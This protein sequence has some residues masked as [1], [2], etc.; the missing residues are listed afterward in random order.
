MAPK[1]TKKATTGTGK[2]ATQTR[3][4]SGAATTSKPAGVSKAAAP[5]KTGK[6]AAGKVKGKSKKADPQD[7]GDGDEDYE[8]PKTKRGRK[9]AE[10]VNDESDEDP[11]VQPRRKHTKK[12]AEEEQDEPPVKQPTRRSARNKKGQNDAE[13]E[14]KDEPQAKPA[15][16]RGTR[17]KKAQDDAGEDQIPHAQPE[18]APARPKRKPKTKTQPAQAEPEE[19]SPRAEQPEPD[20][21][22]PAAEVADGHVQQDAEPDYDQQDPNL[23]QDVFQALALVERTRDCR[24]RGRD[25]SM[26]MELRVHED[27]SVHAD[28][29]LR[30][31]LGYRAKIFLM[32]TAAKGRQRKDEIGYI[33][34]CRIARP[35]NQT[36]NADNDNWRRDFLSGEVDKSVREE[37]EETARCLRALFKN[38]PVA[39]RGKVRHAN[40]EDALSENPLL[41]IAMIYISPNFQRQGLLGTALILFHDLVDRLP[42]YFAFRGVVILTPARPADGKGDVWDG[43]EET[44][45]I[46]RILENSYRKYGGYEVWVEDYKGAGEL[47]TIMGRTL[48]SVGQQM[49]SE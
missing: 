21:V 11:V 35:N 30:S 20:A 3:W 23:D 13:E 15:T 28:P 37:F 6:A 12:A 22:P 49:G 40:H 17:G 5:K 42:E 38:K 25:A 10:S 26:T 47:L 46:E 36:P 34:A 45:T 44:K 32:H 8:P 27:T 43:I 4:K 2:K 9:P 41:Y 16:R 1:K 24:F 19:E 14:E 33:E 29:R 48:P 31:R 7:D 39:D 18:A